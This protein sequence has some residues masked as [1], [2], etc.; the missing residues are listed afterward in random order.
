MEL[1]L[2]KSEK[3]SAVLEIKGEDHTF[4]NALRKELWETGHVD[5]AGYTIA[6]TLTAS[7]ILVVKAKDPRKALE[8][9]SAHLRKK[10]NEMKGLFK[11]K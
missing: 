6:H 9:A 7:P 3:D 5:A 4:C 8:T 2:I 11:K 1:E 10:F